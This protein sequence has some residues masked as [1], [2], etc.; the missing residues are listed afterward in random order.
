MFYLSVSSS[1]NDYLFEDFDLDD[2]YN[3]LEI[4]ELHVFEEKPRN[5]WH[6]SKTIA[7][8][9]NSYV[10]EY[11][12]DEV[13]ILGDTGSYDD[14]Y[15]F[16]DNLEID[17]PIRIVA[18]DED[19]DRKRINGEIYTGFFRQIRSSDPFDNVDVDY[20]IFD[21]GFET[22][23]EGWQIQAAHHPHET[24]RDSSLSKPDSRDDQFLDRLF[25]VD[26]TT[27]Q[28]SFGKITEQQA[29]ADVFIY[30]HAHMP[31]S[32][33]I[34][35]GAEWKILKGLGGR[36]HNYQTTDLVPERSI[37]LSSYSPE[38]LHHLHFDADNDD[39]FEHQIFSDESSDWLENAFW[40]LHYSEDE[41]R[42]RHQDHTESS[43]PVA[44]PFLD[45]KFNE[46]T[47]QFFRPPPTT[48]NEFSR[49]V[50]FDVDVP[51]R[52]TDYVNV[53]KRFG[54]NNVPRARWESEEQLPPSWEI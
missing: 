48:E 11:D 54:K 51:G 15:N 30:D 22:E 26:T 2:N 23:I 31:Y 27:N 41:D 47:G 32:R 9:V 12:V 1:N 16:L 7:E 6:Y 10:E 29:N 42:I 5:R 34:T 18:G 50:M 17:T 49:L 24:L 33:A 3:V 4:S 25:S 37:H 13:W 43:N 8:Q 35:D 39:V 21:E 38:R 52:E 40:S 14:V 36:R 45:F 46:L 20:E 53:Q 44:Q 28:N 19:K